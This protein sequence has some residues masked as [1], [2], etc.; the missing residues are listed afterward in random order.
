MSSPLNSFLRFIEFEKRLS[1][2][3]LVAYKN[4]IEQFSV[5]IEQYQISITE[6]KHTQIR[7]WMVSLMQ[8]GLST[9]SINRKISSLKSFYKFL[10]R[11]KLINSNPFAKVTNPKTS[12]RLPVYVEKN[13]IEQLLTQVEFE[14]GF[15]GIRDKLVIELLYSTGMRRSELT[16]LTE[17]DID[18]WNSQL[19][20]LG[21]GRKERLIPLHP[22]LLN[23]IKNYIQQKHDNYPDVEH[24]YLFIGKKGKPIQAAEVYQTVKKHLATVTTIEKKSPHVLRHTF[25]THMLNEGADI[26]VVKELLGH[27]NLAATQVYTHNTI[28]KLKKIHEQAHPRG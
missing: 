13:N 28:E 16:G 27:A 21:K 10:L 22:Q 2:H 4:D 25:A 3:T 1:N 8:D 9:R 20:V 26:N 11:N 24:P 5:F 7:N 6:V 19:K 15:W 17:T 18:S 14:E 12:K 23:N